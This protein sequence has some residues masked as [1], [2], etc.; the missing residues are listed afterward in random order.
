M[1][2]ILLTL[3]LYLCAVT[4]AFVSDASEIVHARSDRL[5]TIFE[6]AGA[7]HGGHDMHHKTEVLI[8]LGRSDSPKTGKAGENLGTVVDSVPVVGATPNNKKG[9]TKKTEARSYGDSLHKHVINRDR[10][11][12]SGMV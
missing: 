10:H 12:A 2:K 6:H 7:A 1:A 5:S 11:D 3:A 9:A 8:P 4:F